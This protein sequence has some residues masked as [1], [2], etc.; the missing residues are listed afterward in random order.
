[1]KKIKIY[2]FPKK[3]E[4][5][6]LSI[7]TKNVG[8]K[9]SHREDVAIVVFNNMAEA[10]MVL[11]KSKTCAPNIQWLKKI[12]N[13]GKVKILHIN[14]GNANAY[15]GKQGM[16]NVKKIIQCLAVKY[17]CNSKHIIVSSTGVIGEQLP[18][19]KLLSHIDKHK[20]IEGRQNWASLAKSIMTTDTFKKGSYRECYIGKQRVKIM[21]VAKGS[22]MIAPNMATMLGFIFTDADLNSSLLKKILLQAVEKSFNRITVDSDMSTNDM[23]CLFSTKQV[24]CGNLKSENHKLLEQFKLNLEEITIA[25]AKK[26]IVDG[27]GAKK[28]IEIEVTGANSNSEAKNIAF[29]VANSPLV[30]TAVAGEDA[31]WGRVIMAVG[32]AKAKINQELLSLSIGAFPIIISGKLVKN[33]EEKNISKHLKKKE[34]FINIDISIGKGSCKVWTCDLTKE[35]ISINADYRS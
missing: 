8:I 12:K 32:K 19:N 20:I 11:T 35:Y 29:A 13:I 27:E 4:I 10:A 6:G 25:L 26:I 23:V 18:I 9:S 31:N 15:T 16:D 1:M 21:G 3:V 28:L 22:G 34:V 24:S 30:K 17:Y 14:S 2:E 5:K 7:L 33:F